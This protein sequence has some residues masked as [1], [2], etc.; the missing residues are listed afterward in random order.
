MKA[1]FRF[2]WWRP[3]NALVATTNTSNMLSSGG[4][5]EHNAPFHLRNK[6]HFIDSTSYSLTF[7]KLLRHFNFSPSCLSLFIISSSLLYKIHCFVWI[8]KTSKLI[9]YL[10]SVSS[11][12]CCWRRR[13]ERWSQSCKPTLTFVHCA[14]YSIQSAH[15]FGASCLVKAT[16]LKLNDAHMRQ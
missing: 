5:H 8:N 7:D 3:R 12:C 15:G 9:N 16:A 14:I 13:D 1:L 4:N 10:L 11:F 2:I 6:T